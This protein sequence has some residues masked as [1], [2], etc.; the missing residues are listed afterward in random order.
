MNCLCIPVV[1]LLCRACVGVNYNFDRIR[2][3]TGSNGSSLNPSNLYFNCAIKNFFNFKQRFTHFHCILYYSRVFRPDK[4]KIW[5]FNPHQT[6]DK[7]K[8]I[9]IKM[10]FHCAYFTG[11]SNDGKIFLVHQSTLS[12]AAVLSLPICLEP[13][14]YTIEYWII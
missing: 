10:T 7:N 6:N 8:T 12:P 14:L 11:C 4:I 13:I 2:T 1:F 5:N 3:R 9:A